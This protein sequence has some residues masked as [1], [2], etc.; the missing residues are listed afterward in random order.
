MIHDKFTMMVHRM[1]SVPLDV[2]RA[3]WIARVGIEKSLDTI[4]AGLLEQGYERVVAD[5]PA[6][7]DG[8]QVLRFNDRTYALRPEVHKERLAAE[9]EAEKATRLASETKSVVGTESISALV[10]PKCGDSLQY[11]AVCPKCG[12]GKLGYRHRY[13]CVCGG[14]DIVSKEAL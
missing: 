4:E 6:T 1:A 7:T 8:R 9:F 14:T 11:T 10:C 12:A 13:L 3:A 2:A 5:G